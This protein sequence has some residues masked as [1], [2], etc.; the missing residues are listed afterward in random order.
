MLLL[1]IDSVRMIWTWKLD[2]LFFHVR[3]QEYSSLEDLLRRALLR[4]LQFGLTSEFLYYKELGAYTVRQLFVIYS[5]A[6][7]EKHPE[8]PPEIQPAA[9][10]H[11]L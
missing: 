11:S 5:F 10:S 8:P 2:L 9:L 4:G 1:I 6:I 3:T 7:A